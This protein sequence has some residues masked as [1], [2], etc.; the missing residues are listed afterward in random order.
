MLAKL[1]TSSVHAVIT[2][3][4]YAIK[5]PSASAQSETVKQRPD[6]LSAG[7][8]TGDLCADC[9]REGAES[10]FAESNMLGQ[11]SQKWHAK[12]A[13]LRG[14]A[15]NDPREFQTWC[16]LWLHECFR[17]LNPGGRLV[18]F[19]G[20]RTWHRLATAAE[21]SGFEIRDSLAWLYSSGMPKSLNVER[22]LAAQDRPQAS[23]T[24]TGSG[25][26]LKPAFEPIVLGRK[27]LDGTMVQNVTKWGVG[28]LACRRHRASTT[29][30]AP[31]AVAPPQASGRATY[32]STSVNPRNLNRRRGRTRP[33]SSGCRNQTA[34]NASSSTASNP[35]VKPRAISVGHRSRSRSRGSRFA[36]RERRA[37]RRRFGSRWARV[38]PCGRAS[39][40]P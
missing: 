15:D 31:A 2:D 17:I 12:E 7:C 3:P 8:R 5:P 25:T 27:P 29:S 23:T 40:R 39:A 18:A 10:R 24:W 34:T 11:Q 16:R 4:P 30:T 14:Y 6:C 26:A 9:V 22:A 32:T 35:T 37:L 28:P 13:H 38:L 36:C 21:D 1:P 33:N 20:T 19:G